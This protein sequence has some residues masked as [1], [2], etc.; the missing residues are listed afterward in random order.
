MQ[1]GLFKE[2]FVPINPGNAGLA[3][4]ASLMVAE[5]DGCQ[6]KPVV[7]P[8]LGAGYESEA[9]K[10]TLDSCKLSY[11]FVSE[12][13]A[14]DAAVGALSRGHLVGWFQGRME[15]GHRAL[16]H[17][18]ILANP[19]CEYVLDNLN[20]FLR[21]RERSRPFGVSVCR[22]DVHGLF[23]GPP[24][25]PWMEYEYR[26]RGDRF[27]HVIPIGA[28]TIRVQTVTQDQQPFWALLKKMEQA[29]GVAALVNTSF[30]GFHEPIVCSPRDA[31]RVFFGTGLDMLVIGRFVLRK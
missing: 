15:W 6:N 5:G 24:S 26:P 31:V 4:G 28:S 10:E 7:S 14:Q 13:E 21:K 20:F 19:L 12:T 30:N 25:S 16:G 2:T 22:D 23:C 29:T 11:E 9:V 1:S 3:I 17:R 18:S 8:F 27:R